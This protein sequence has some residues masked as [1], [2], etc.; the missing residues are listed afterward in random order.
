MKSYFDIVKSRSS[1]GILILDADHRVVYSNQAALDFL[2]GL[3]KRIASSEIRDLCARLRDQSP[4]KEGAHCLIVERTSGLPFSLRAFPLKERRP[5]KTEDFIMILVEKIVDRHLADLD[6]DRV[7]NDHGLS[8]REKGVLE[9]ICQGL[10]N[11]DISRKLF[12]SEYTV[13]DHIKNILSKM[14]LGSR[15]EI[16]A[17]LLQP[18]VHSK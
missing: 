5:E 16:I 14:N 11:S 4:K 10:S 3:R 6:F 13:K 17:S 15:S 7:G 1:P 9:L 18:G 2:P 8:K 12:I